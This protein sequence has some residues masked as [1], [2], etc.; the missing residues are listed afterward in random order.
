MRTAARCAREGSVCGG[1][2]TDRTVADAAA[3]AHELEEKGFR[4]LAVAVGTTTMR[5]AGII[6]LSD[7]PRPMRPSSSRSC[8]RWACAP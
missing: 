7:P 6:A 8:A 4:V 5:L 1:H 2:Q 3:T